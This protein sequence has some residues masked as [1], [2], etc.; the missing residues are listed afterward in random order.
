MLKLLIR[1]IKIKRPWNS[2]LNLWCWRKDLEAVEMKILRYLLGI[3]MLCE[4]RNQSVMEKL[5]VPDI[6]LDIQHYERKWLQ[7]L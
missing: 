3:P 5:E 7:H 2:A 6:V 1:N 4:E